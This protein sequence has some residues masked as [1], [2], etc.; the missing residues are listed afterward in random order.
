MPQIIRIEIEEIV[1][2]QKLYNFFKIVLKILKKYILKKIKS[3]NKKKL[4]SLEF[5]CISN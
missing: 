4:I 2:I 3:Q 5:N 1:E